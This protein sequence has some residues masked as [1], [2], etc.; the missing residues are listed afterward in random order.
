MWMFAHVTAIFFM[1]GAFVEATG[2]KRPWL[3]G[4]LVGAAGLARL[5]VFLTFPFFAYLLVDGDARPW[6]DLA[7]DR[8]VILRLG[9]FCAGLAAMAALDLLY[10][11]E[12]FGTIEDKGYHYAPY[13]SE[14]HFAQGMNDLGYVDRHLEAIFIRLPVLD[15]SS[16][17]Y[18]KPSVLGLGLFF[19]TP[20]FLY[21]FRA[22][23]NR[24]TIAAIVATLLTLVPIVTY[25]VVGAAQFGYRYGID[26]Y[27]MLL[28]L[29][30]SGMRYEMSRMKWALVGLSCLIGL[31]GV[32]SF[33]HFNW[34][35]CTPDW[36]CGSQP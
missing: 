25:G 13:L 30:A 12:R 18:L 5:P 35:A 23:L 2:T 28:V 31:W 33:E 6:M 32:L 10:N 7:R 15:F 36:T 29:T 19:T 3:V 22:K 14:P 20:A 34:V 9:L 1:M 4:L 16:F 17:P 26:T 21:I 24:L 11:Y 27:P 8:G